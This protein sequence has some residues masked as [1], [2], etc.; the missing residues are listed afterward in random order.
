MRNTHHDDRGILDRLNRLDVHA[1][2]AA[3][4]DDTHAY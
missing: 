3:D 2:D 4:T 1:A